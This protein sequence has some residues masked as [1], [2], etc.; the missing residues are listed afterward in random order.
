[1]QAPTLRRLVAATALVAAAPLAS[2]EAP[3][4]CGALPGAGQDPFARRAEI[5]AEY[6]RLPPACLQDI[7]AACA[8]AANESL[9]DLGSAAVCSFGY[10]ALL[11]QRFGGNFREL[12]AWWQTQRG[13]RLH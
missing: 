10:E 5:L 2:A 7:F 9:L 1:M 6:R 12:M 8:S 13:T 11:S 4:S 3:A